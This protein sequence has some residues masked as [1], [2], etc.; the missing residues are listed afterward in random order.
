MTRFSP[1]HQI[2]QDVLDPITPA[3]TISG[4]TFAKE[5]AE[6]IPSALLAS[7]ENLDTAKQVQRA[8]Y[9]R[10]NESIR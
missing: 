1:A 7:A 2:I 6:G 5:V 10:Q 9:Y 8:F 3:A 4:P